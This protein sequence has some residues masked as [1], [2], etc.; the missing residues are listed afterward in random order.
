LTELIEDVYV[1]EITSSSKFGS[2]IKEND[3][4]K[5][6][7]ITDSNGNVK[8]EMTVQRSHNLPDVML[9]VRA[10]DTVTLVVERGG[11]EYTLSETYSAADI[12]DAD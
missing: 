7:K 2:S 10:G 1:S 5:S 12:S 4:L 8:E 9:S 11:V 6:I 3:K